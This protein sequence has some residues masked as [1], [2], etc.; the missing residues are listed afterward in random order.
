MKNLTSLIGR[1]LHVLHLALFATLVFL[2]GGA[3]AQIVTEFSAGSVAIAKLGD[4]TAGPDGNLWFTYV[5]HV[6]TGTWPFFAPIGAIGRITPQGVVTEVGTGTL[7]GDPGAITAGPDGNL[8]FAQ[9]GRIGRITPLGVVTEF[10]S[11]IGVGAVP[12]SITAGPDGNL[13]FTEYGGNRIGRI[14]PAGVVTE[15]SA[16]ISVGAWPA[17]ITAGPDGNLWFTEEVGRIGRITPAGVVTEFSSGISASYYA[18]PRDIAAGP[19]G[20]LWF[21]ETPLNRIGRITSDGVVTEFDAGTIG[22]AGPAGIAVGPD[23]HLWFTKSGGIGRMTLQGAA[24]AFNAGISTG[25]APHS[26]TAG[27]D[28]NLWFTEYPGNRIG[29]ITACLNEAACTPAI[30]AVVSSVNPS[31]HGQAIVFTASVAGN[32]ATG[33]VQ[34]MDGGTNLGAPVTLS[35][36]GI[37]QLMTSKLTAG[38]HAISAVYSGDNKNGPSASSVLFQIVGKVR[39]RH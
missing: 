37:A 20:N 27:P 21:T 13:W 1:F 15:F 6:A 19:D 18:S 10:S 4:I 34:F 14:T 23:G 22:G 36:G 35:G 29:R 3:G 12:H 25:A 8:W 31:Q 17:G 16:G 39:K 38:T 28:G 2:A 26:I 30:T 33:T 7:A 32:F 24:T 11:G 9:G 5:K